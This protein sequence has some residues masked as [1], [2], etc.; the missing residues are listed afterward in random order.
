MNR[1]KDWSLARCRLDKQLRPTRADWEV[2]GNGKLTKG[3]HEALD[4]CRYGCPIL[5]MC[6]AFAEA[7]HPESLIQGGIVWNT[8]GTA[9]RVTELKHRTTP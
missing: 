6:R 2:I 8:H 3:N 9:R 7:I 1:R 4:I 5:E